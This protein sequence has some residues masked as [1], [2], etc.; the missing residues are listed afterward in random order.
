M[1]WTFYNSSGEAMIID[2]GLHNLLEDT[3][4]QLGGNLDMVAKL[5]VG[6]G[7]S[8]GIA[9]SAAGEVTMA[10]QPAFLAQNSADDTNVTGTGA[11]AV[12]D[13]DTEIFDRNG[14]FTGDTFTAPVT[15]IYDLAAFVRTNTGLDTDSND[16]LCRITGSGIRTV[17]LAQQGGLPDAVETASIYGGSVLLDMDA[18]DT[19]T[20]T[21][22]VSGQGGATVD[23]DGHGSILLTYFCG[24]L[25]A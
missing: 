14:D 4:P 19:A 7:G 10:A 18:G 11:A 6:N 17:Y 1:P 16:I 5:L 22:G 24:R 23:I 2:G 8:T 25:V 3:T 20:V 9:I 15:G 12:I 13:F 21:L